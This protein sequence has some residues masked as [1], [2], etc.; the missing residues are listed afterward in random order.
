MGNVTKDVKVVRDAIVKFR[1]DL[2]RAARDLTRNP[3][4]AED[5]VQASCLRALEYGHRLRTQDN[6]RGWLSTIMRNVLVDF[7]RRQARMVPL[8]QVGE[9]VAAQPEGL[10]PWSDLSVEDVWAALAACSPPL[11]AV[12]ELQVLRG[13]SG[14]ETARRLGIPP[15]TVASRMS[16][17]RQRLRQILTPV[18]AAPAPPAGA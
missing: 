13:L 17:A 2:I 11:R 18:A 5:I 8:D 16:R 10:E 3:T 6:L 7:W 15:G 12:Y 14:A 4:D 1:S 9:P